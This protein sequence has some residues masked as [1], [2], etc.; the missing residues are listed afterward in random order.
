MTVVIIIISPNR[1]WRHQYSN[2]ST[3]QWLQLGMQLTDRVRFAEN[4]SPRAAKG[5]GCWRSPISSLAVNAISLLIY[6]NVWHWRT[7]RVHG[8]VIKLNTLTDLQTNRP[9]LITVHTHLVSHTH[10]QT[11]YIKNNNNNNNNNNKNAF[12]RLF[13]ITRTC[14]KVCFLYGKLVSWTHS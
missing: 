6:G 13:L 14:D 5:A 9:F 1:T 7:K 8:V 10:C 11:L 3:R 4:G 2:L 12:S